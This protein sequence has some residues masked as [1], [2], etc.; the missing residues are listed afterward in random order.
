MSASTKTTAVKSVP[1]TAE[2]PEKGT[3]ITAPQSVKDSGKVH[4]GGM[5]MRF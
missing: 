3:S 2:R 5:M 4:I 1:A